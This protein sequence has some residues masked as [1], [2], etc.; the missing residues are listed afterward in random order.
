LLQE[1]SASQGEIKIEPPRRKKL[2]IKINDEE[3]AYEQGDAPYKVY[4]KER[5][6]KYRK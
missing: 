3:T 6:M 4:G 5:F 1:E 2:K